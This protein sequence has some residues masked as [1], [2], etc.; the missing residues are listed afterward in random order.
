MDRQ[1]DDEGA[2]SARTVAV[3]G[4]HPFVQVDEVPHERQAEAQAFRRIGRALVLDEQLEDAARLGRIEALARVGYGQPRAVVLPLEHHVDPTVSGR[5]LDRVV[6]QIH[7]HLH[8]PRRVAV[9]VEGEA[10]LVFGLLGGLLDGVLGP[11]VERVSVGALALRL[12]DVA[13]EGIVLGLQGGAVA[14][15]DLRQRRQGRIG[16]VA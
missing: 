4:D 12:G 5:V 14:G 3:G 15:E 9:D 13:G 1:R 10:L 7:E 16:R 6:E 2:P 11:L 8:Q